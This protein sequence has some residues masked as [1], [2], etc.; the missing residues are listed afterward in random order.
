MSA[1][2]AFCLLFASGFTTGMGSDI[3]LSAKVASMPMIC[4]VGLPLAVSIGMLAGGRNIASG[5]NFSVAIDAPSVT[6]IPAFTAGSVFCVT[7][8]GV[9]MV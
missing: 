9:L 8:F 3:K 1:Y 7:H 2:R 5:G 6:G 4:A